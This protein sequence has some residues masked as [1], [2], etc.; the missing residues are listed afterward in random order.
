MFGRR[1]A[2]WGAVAGMVILTPF[3]F[4]VAVDRLPFRGLKRF[5][6]YVTQSSQGN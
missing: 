2:F 6:D 5:R 3:A 1:L 4:N